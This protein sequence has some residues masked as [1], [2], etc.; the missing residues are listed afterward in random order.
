MVQVAKSSEFKLRFL[1]QICER[2]NAFPYVYSLFGADMSQIS[3]TNFI[4]QYFRQILNLRAAEYK[5]LALL[6]SRS[7]LS[8]SQ[9]FF[10]RVSVYL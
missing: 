8:S 6:S 4:V 1:C 9:S 3:K 5:I 10:L 2:K 7:S